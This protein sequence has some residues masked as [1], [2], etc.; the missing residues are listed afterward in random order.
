MRTLVIDVDSLRPDHVGAYGYPEPTTPNIDRLAED[1]VRFDRAYAAA[2]PCMPARAAFLSGR[3]GIANG[4]ATHG[5]RGRTLSGPD[6][7]A[8]FDGDA[9]DYRTLP[10]VLFDDRTPTA[11]VS[12]FPRH[13]SPWFYDR[14]HEFHQP[15]EPPGDGE[16]FQTPRAE[17]VADRALSWLDRVESS[18]WLLYVQFWDPHT[19]YNRTDEETAQ[20]DPPRPPH[21]TDEAIARQQADTYWRSAPHQGINNAADLLDTLAAYDA[22]IRYC[23]RHVGRVL[24]ALRERGVYD[25]TL[26]VLL[27]DHGEEFGEHGCYSEH[28]STHEGTQRIPLLVKP[29]G[30]ADRAA[31]DALVTNVDVAPTILDYAGPDRPA[32]WHGRS[33]RPLVADE[34][35]DWRDTVVLDHGLYTAQR[36]VRTDRWK[37]VRTYHDGLWEIPDRQLFDLQADPWEQE[38]VREAHPEV[39]DRLEGRMARWADRYV[40]REEDALRAVAREGPAGLRWAGA[41]VV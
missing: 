40:G 31:S 6:T 35:P 17:T 10:A 5:P 23:D 41:D 26:I 30:G 12:S 24:D 25:E 21:P 16:T 1:A 3:Y 20:F 11:A 22:E 39:V 19:P 13:P 14:W 4:V 29:P 27:A 33:V 8:D 7:W 2:S 32:A 15:Q 34:G 37:F 38:N 18:A 28:W 36:A 9:A